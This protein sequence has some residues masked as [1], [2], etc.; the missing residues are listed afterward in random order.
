MARSA[1]SSLR[2]FWDEHR[3]LLVVALTYIALGGFVQTV[4]L[5]RP[6]PIQVTT[7]WFARIWMWGSTIWLIAH[8]AGR[9]RGT[10]PRLSADQLIGAVLLAMLAVPVQT[11]FQSL[12]QSLGVVRGFPWDERLAAIDS[13]IHGGPAWHLFGFILDHPAIL[14]TIDVL[15]VGW[16]L[17]LLATVVWLCWTRSRLLRQQGLLALLFLWIGAGTLAAWGFA[18]AGPCYRAAVDPDA[19]ALL[20]RLDASQSAMIARQNQLG[21]WD[22]FVAERWLTFGGVSAMPSLHVGLAV[23]VALIVTRRNRYIG[24]ALWAYAAIVQVGS[25]VL[26]WHYG[27]DGYAGALCAWGAWALAGVIARAAVEQPVRT[28][29]FSAIERLLSQNPAPR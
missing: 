9:R 12:K 10:R 4:I 19:A 23:L 3:V 14:K 25:V 27:I 20:A 26:A 29:R 6:W 15:Y 28:R 8:V 2:L 22:G 18:S 7:G 13:A 21:V 1:L 24:A 11:T 5:H 17:A 16:F